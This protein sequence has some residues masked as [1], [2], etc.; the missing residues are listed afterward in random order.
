MCVGMW[1]VRE[2][3]C[4]NAE[5]VCVNRVLACVCTFVNVS[6]YVWMCRQEWKIGYSLIA[7][8]LL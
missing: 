6:E 1:S 2:C 7:V 4:M 3:T 5:C 8:K